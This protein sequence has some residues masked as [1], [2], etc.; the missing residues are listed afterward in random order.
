MRAEEW[1][2]SPHNRESPEFGYLRQFRGSHSVIKRDMSFILSRTQRYLRDQISRSREFE[3]ELDM[4]AKKKEHSEKL[5]LARNRF[6]DSSDVRAPMVSFLELVP[7]VVTRSTR[8]KR[9]RNTCTPSSL[10]VNCPI[11]ITT[12][13]RRGGAG[14][15]GDTQRPG[16]VVVKIK[17]AT[18]PPRIALIAG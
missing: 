1:D 2:R 6:V 13:Q 9:W 16:R 4:N 11:K 3:D 7:I 17:N 12:R 8:R 10:R 15:S 14:Q 5:G 18:R